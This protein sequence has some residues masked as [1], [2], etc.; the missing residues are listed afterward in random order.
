MDHGTHRTCR[1][2]FNSQTHLIDIYDEFELNIADIISEHIGQVG[3][4]ITH[5]FYMHIVFEL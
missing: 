2:C 1:L 5:L 4:H 3:N